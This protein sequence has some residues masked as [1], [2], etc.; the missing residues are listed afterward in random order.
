MQNKVNKT[1]TENNALTFKS[2]QSKVLDLFSMGGALRT[3]TPE[4]I[5]K[6]VSQALAEDKLLAIK[7]LFYLRDVRGGG[8]GERRTGR[9]GLG[10]LS[11][12]YPEETKKLLPLIPEYGREDD[13]FYI[14]GIDISI[15]LKD[16]L[17]KDLKEIGGEECLRIIKL[18]QR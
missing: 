11:K 5:E 17:I 8:M 6:F 2:T 13:I 15:Y 9:I 14:D 7:C 3:R 10:V 18:L 12:Y 1:F 4:E 16:K